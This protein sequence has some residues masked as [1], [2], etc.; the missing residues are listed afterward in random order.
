TASR[1]AVQVLKNAL[2]R[3]LPEKTA[4]QMGIEAANRRIFDMQRRDSSLSGM[5]TT[6]TLLWESD[7]SLL[8]GHVGDSRAYLLRDG[9]LAQQTQDH[10]VVAE[11][12]RN[13]LI[14]PEAAKTHP[15]RN[16]I[17]RALGTDPSV[18]A[19]VTS[20]EKK[21]GDKW[22]VCSDGLY[23]MVDDERIEAALQTL[24]G[25][26]AAESLLAQALQNGGADNISLIVGVVAEVTAP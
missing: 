12:V 7:D 11:L 10:S 16:V 9:K 6:L 14:T 3:R 20:V 22:L 21:P 5:G 24:S 18:L 1:V 25:E 4:L 19:D 17:T 23:G 2:Q 13:K 26:E 8:I 15:Y